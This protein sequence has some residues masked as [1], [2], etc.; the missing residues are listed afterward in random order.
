VSGLLIG[1]VAHRTGLTVATIRYYETIGLL[2]TPSR[3]TAGYRRYTETTVEELRFVKK[4]QALGFSLEEIGEILTLSR[5]GRAPCSHVLDLA[6]RHLKAVEDRIHQLTHFRDQLAY[7][8]AKWHGERQPTCQGLC[9][10]IAG[11]DEQPSD[12]VPG[13]LCPRG[14]RVSKTRR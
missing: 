11:A 3:S 10:I 14:R 5:A 1:N 8:L 13:D 9:Q 7:E 2:P 4:A 6:H 12:V